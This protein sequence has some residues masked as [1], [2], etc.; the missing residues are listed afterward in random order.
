MAA[1]VAVTCRAGYVQ[2]QPLAVGVLEDLMRVLVMDDGVK[3]APLVQRAL[4][5]ETFAVDVAHDGRTGLDVAMPHAYD[6]IISH[7]ARSGR[8][9]DS[10]EVTGGQKAYARAG[11]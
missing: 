6:L 4:T 11:A 7:A 5:E 1:P 2:R 3:V 10:E 9:S 8:R